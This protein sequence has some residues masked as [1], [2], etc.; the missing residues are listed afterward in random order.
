MNHQNP[1]AKAEKSSKGILGAGLLTAF[2]ASL[3]CITPVLALFSG[4]TGI[5]STFS[6]MEP[7]RPY[8]LGITVVVLGFAWYQKIKPRKKDEVACDCE[9]DKPSFW[10]GKTFL[11]IW[12][13]LAFLLMAFPKYSYIFYPKIE[14]KEVIVIDKN[15]IQEVKLNIN[16]MDCEACTHSINN[17]LSKLP[18]VLEYKTEYEKGASTVKFDNSKINKENI[19]KVIDATGYKVSGSEISITNPPHG[20]AGHI[21]GPNGCK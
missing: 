2:A 16:G 10:K 21:C 11:G 18:G 12:T 14:K 19:I 20:Q 5:A 6:W 13:V 17:A 1:S 8:L 15:N 9:E 3:C 4:A 7:Y